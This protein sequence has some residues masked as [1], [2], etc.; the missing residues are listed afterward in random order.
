MIKAVIFDVGGVLIRTHD[1]TPRRQWEWKL[2]LAEWQSE[3][4]VFNSEMG[5]Q[6]QKG[7]ITDEALWQWVGE[8]LD[9]SAL[10]LAKF[11]ADF[12][13]GDALDSELVNFVRR[14]RP[15][16]QTA[17][18][19]NAT[20]GLLN[21]L[22]K[23]YKIADAFDLIV[24][25]AQEKVMKPAPEIFHRTL[26]RLK[27]KPEEVVFIDDFTHNVQAAQALGWH[28]IHFQPGISVPVELAKLGVIPPKETGS[29]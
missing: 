15:T 13:A 2:G 8:R 7:E 17:I 6:A 5:Y 11:R 20:D 18:I 19:S 9:L 28:T 29:T 21:S 3:Q 24:S 14:L 25:S 22:T 16:Y 23:E 26:L 4:I 12:W 10:E 27:R 1:H